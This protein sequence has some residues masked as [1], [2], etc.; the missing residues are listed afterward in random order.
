MTAIADGIRVIGIGNGDRGDDGIGPLIAERLRASAP[1]DVS[2]LIR[3][4][5]AL[6]LIDDWRGADSAILVDAAAPMTA[7]GVIHRIDLIADVVPSELS[8]ASTHAFGI[9][10]AV[11]LAYTLGL[12]PRHLILYAVEGASFAPGAA[13]TPEVAGAAGPAARRILDEIESL[14]RIEVEVEADA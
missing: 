13:V 5:D 11:G 3:R 8:L 6:A 2:V 12:L 10:Q 4:G 9:S 7:P 1:S 14:R